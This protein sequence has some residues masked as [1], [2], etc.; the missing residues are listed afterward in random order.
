MT[1]V[2]AQAS[3]GLSIGGGSVRRVTDIWFVE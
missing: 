3:L 1:N 2:T